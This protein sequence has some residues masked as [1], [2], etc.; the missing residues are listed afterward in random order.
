MSA[1]SISLLGL[2]PARLRHPPRLLSSSISHTLT[3]LFIVAAAETVT[4]WLAFLEVAIFAGVLKYSTGYS[5]RVL[6]DEAYENGLAGFVCLFKRHDYTEEVAV[7]APNEE[8]VAHK[9]DRCGKTVEGRI[10]R[11]RG[12]E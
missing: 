8:L 5:I 11:Q 12:E 10:P 6:A 1:V 9:C 3:V 4:S 7:E 2:V